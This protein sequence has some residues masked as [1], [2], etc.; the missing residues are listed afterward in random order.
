MRFFLSAV[1]L[2]EMLTPG[3]ARADSAAK[4]AGAETYIF[5]LTKVEL[6]EGVP[7]GVEKAVRRELGRAIAGRKELR[8]SPGEGAPDPEKDPPEFER[9]LKSK[10][11]R[12]FKVNVEVT[13]YQ[14]EVTEADQPKRFVSVHIN[15]RLFGETI[16]GRKFAF[17]GDG[18]A[19]IK[20]EIG[21]KLRP[22]DQEY[23]ESE[24][25]KSAV[26]DA[27]TSSIQKLRLPPANPNGKKARKSAGAAAGGRRERYNLPA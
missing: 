25:I 8:P 27:L 18:A 16:P 20:I 17:T 1:V 14:S 24:A 4:N 19:T 9:Y 12:A 7:E 6:K 11:M 2:L 22:S 3:A 10:R 21:K 26:E 13:A 15:L 23:A 5:E